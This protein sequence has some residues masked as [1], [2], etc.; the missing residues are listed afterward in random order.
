MSLVY[1]RKFLIFIFVIVFVVISVVFVSRV[2]CYDTN[3]AHPFLT[4]QAIELFNKNSDSKISEQEIKW[5]VRGAVEEDT[6][7][8]WMN[9][10]FEPTNNKGL[11]GFSTAKQWSKENIKQKAY[12]KGNRTWQ[13]AV[14]SYTKGDKKE[15][16]IALGHILHLIEDMSVPAH[17]RIDIHIKGDSYEEWAKKNVSTNFTAES[18]A[19]FESLDEYFNLLASYSN[20]YFLSADTINQNELLKKERFFKKI[21]ETEA[22]ECIKGE[23]EFRKF[24]L[25]VV[26]KDLTK[27]NYI[28]DD[29]VHADYYSLLAPKAIS[30]SAGV[31][32]VALK[33]K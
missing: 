23:L 14:E 30:Y 5:I 11:T 18:I 25:V 29:F 4:K 9:H 26:K 15:A 20:R 2:F 1:K 19:K 21:S 27:E 28:L 13:K 17:T 7:I 32:S 22:I 6:P 16:F 24:C 31:T 3:V 12:A 8:R 33:I 10:F